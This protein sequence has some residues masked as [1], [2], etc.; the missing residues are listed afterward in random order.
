MEMV[1]GGGG[2]GG[3]G[4]ANIYF[5]VDDYL[6]RMYNFVLKIILYI[7]KNIREEDF[8]KSPPREYIFHL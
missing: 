6:S 8:F 1:T 7:P 4:F 3:G 2:G 5:R